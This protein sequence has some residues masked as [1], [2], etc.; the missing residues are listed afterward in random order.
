M[1]KMIWGYPGPSWMLCGLATCAV[2]W[3]PWRGC[4]TP[5]AH[6]CDNKSETQPRAIHWAPLGAHIPLAPQGSNTVSL[7]L[8][9]CK[10]L[11]LSCVLRI[12]RAAYC[13]VKEN[14]RV[15]T[16]NQNSMV[17]FPE[18]KKGFNG[19]SIYFLRKMVL[20]RVVSWLNCLKNRFKRQMCKTGCDIFWK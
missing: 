11:N 14:S 5:G 7:C 17:L 1:K 19:C 10:C 9:L 20:N 12:V 4:P 16:P 3:A 8:G 18:R 15:A 13:V 2:L 6:E